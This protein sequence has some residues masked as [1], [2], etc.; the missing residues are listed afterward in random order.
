MS[1][2]SI[3]ASYT[4]ISPGLTTS[5]SVIGG[6]APYS[7]SVLPGGIGGTISS[8][9]IYSASPNSY[10]LDTVLVQDSSNPVNQA[11]L[12][13][14]VGSTIQLVCDILQQYL[15][16]SQGQVIIFNTK[17]TLPTDSRMYIAVGISS[18]KS[19]GNSNTTY[20]GVSVQGVNMRAMLDINIMS[21]SID[22]LNQK[23]QVLLAFSS[24][25][26]ENQM[27]KNS[28]FIAPNASTFVNLSEI[29]GAAIPYRFVIGCNLLYFVPSVMSTAY[30]DEFAPVTVVVDDD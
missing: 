2:L 22:A 17:W 1:S 30:F 12:D 11:T 16:L 8:S 19:F 15:Q 18:L 24:Q 29:D 21:R 10:G 27:E 6:N 14:L 7:F 25:Y 13:I 5:L 28:F 26:A 23:E 9:G 20:N 4:A 3:S